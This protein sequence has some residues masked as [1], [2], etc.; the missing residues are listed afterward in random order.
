MMD[1]A[2]KSKKQTFK[3]VNTI[4]YYYPKLNTG[5]RQSAIV[6]MLEAFGGNIRP[7]TCNSFEEY[8]CKVLREQ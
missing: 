4:T 8:Y 3:P 5:K 1:T 6:E 7:V 2:A